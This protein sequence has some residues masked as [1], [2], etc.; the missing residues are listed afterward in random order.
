M[1]I[2]IAQASL[3]FSGDRRALEDPRLLVEQRSPFT[4]PF[5]WGE[6]NDFSISKSS[7]VPA[8]A[9]G[10][11]PLR[12]LPHFR[13]PRIIP[14]F[15]HKSR[16]NVSRPISNNSEVQKRDAERSTSVQH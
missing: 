6:R 9:S 4:S 15:D 14:Q 2:D 11:E 1:R 16:E 10:G 7:S 3:A 8:S 12:G 5:A 13:G